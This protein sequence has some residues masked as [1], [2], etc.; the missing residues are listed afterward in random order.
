M[1]KEVLNVKEK[2]IE[3]N[4]NWYDETV[5][6]KASNLYTLMR[7]E[8]IYTLGAEDA[9]QKIISEILIDAKF[10]GFDESRYEFENA[11]YF[12]WDQMNATS[13]EY[14]DKMIE[15]FDDN[16]DSYS[17]FNNIMNKFG[18]E[19]DSV[20]RRDL[21]NNIKIQILDFDSNKNV[22]RIN[23]YSPNQFRKALT[24]DI[25]DFEEFLN[26]PTNFI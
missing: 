15:K 18:F 21:G 4:E 5:S 10:A 8:N 12:D 16:Q 7:I 24:V 25:D 11:K 22:V 6:M 3:E 19:V 9:I 23:V 13:I 20:T 1:Q 17:K 26:N 2:V 14:L